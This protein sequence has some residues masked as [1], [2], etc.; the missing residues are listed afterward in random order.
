LHSVAPGHAD[1]RLS[2]PDS[3]FTISM[4]RQTKLHVRM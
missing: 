4:L 1:D 2:C 3:A